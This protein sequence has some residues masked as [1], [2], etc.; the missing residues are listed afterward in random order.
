MHPKIIKEAKNQ[1]NKLTITS[2]SFHSDKLALWSEYVCNYFNYDKVLPMNSG[3]EAVETAI[4]LARKFGYVN[5][6]IKYGNAKI[7]TFNN[8]FHGR[9]IEVLSGSTN[10]SYKHYFEPFSD[11][12]I[13]CEFNN[14]EMFKNIIYNNSNVCAALIEPIQ[15]EGGVIVPDNGY[16]FELKK[17]CHQNKILFIADEIQT[18]IGRTGKLL[19]SEYDNVK[20]DIVILAKSLGGGIVP[21]SCIVASNDLMNLFDIGSHGFTFGGNPFA[22]AVSI[23]SL[24]VVRDEEMI[25]NAYE[26]GCYFRE[27]INYSPLIKQI[28][29]KGLL[30]GIEFKVDELNEKKLDL[31]EICEKFMNNGLLAKNTSMNTIRFSPPLIIN[32]EQMDNALEIINNTISKL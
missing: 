19:C 22:C 32:K 10:N 7:I 26:M 21:I 16:L 15:G 2:R 17:I 27:N 23:K 29:G 13:N 24:E 5:K 18:G 28:R 14:L 4:K 6:N 1:L 11:G 25:K 12:F 8:N 30:N 20:P 31:Y 3:A 9:T